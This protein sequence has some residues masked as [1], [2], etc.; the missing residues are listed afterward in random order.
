M[1]GTCGQL[2][3]LGFNLN[4]VV[5]ELAKKELQTLVG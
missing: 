5:R 1:M 3:A 2:A 4:K